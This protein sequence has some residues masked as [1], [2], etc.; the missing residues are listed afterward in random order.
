MNSVQRRQQ[1]WLRRMSRRQMLKGMV[2]AGALASA[3]ALACREEQ[4]QV[5]PAPVQEET[6]RPGGTVRA[7]LVGLSS[8]NPPTL[9]PYKELTYLAQIPASWHYS[10]LVKFQAGPNIDPLDF[11]VVEG[12]L[13][14]RWEIPDPQMY[15]FRLRPN[16]RFHNVPPLNGRPLT[17]EDIL[18]S[19]RRISQDSPNRGSWNDV[20]DRVEAPDDR[21][22]IVRLKKVFAPGLNHFANPELFRVQ[23]KELIDAGL[24][25]RP[26]GT[27]PFIFEAFERDVAIKWRKNPDYFIADRPYVDRWEASLVG[28]PSTI[29][30]NLKTGTFDLALLDPAVY[31]TAKTEVPDLTFTYNKNQ[32]I[33]GFYF[34]FDKEPW[35]DPR[36]RQALS[37]SI[38]RDGILRVMDPTGQGGWFSAI[39]QLV[40][41]WLDPKDQSRFGPNARYFQRDVAEARRLLAA[42]GYPNGIDARVVYS[43][44]YGKAY[45]QLFTLATTTARDAGF[46]LQLQP[47]EYA[48]YLTTTFRGN[49]QPDG[50]AIGPLYVAVEPDA[51]FFTVYHPQSARKN[52]GGTGPASLDKDTQLLQM[53]DA[54]R[55]ELNADR[56]VQ[57]IHD[58]QRYM[59]EKMYMVPYSALPG[60][61]GFRPWV[62]GLYYKSSFGYGA[63]VAIHVWLAR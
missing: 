19:A 28:D 31:N 21:T 18:F 3:S 14:E 6:P 22:V 54:Q 32:V 43:P 1:L 50:I 52:W 58:I 27:G 59:A 20:V 4:P 40:P 47:Q 23:P 34:N 29:I 49:I 12:D 51:I 46:R 36:V 56:R 55:Q 57:L 13:A 11:S 24:Q 2:A 16:I 45:E 41:F 60:V 42:A 53:F 25:E 44:V 10:R 9:D 17:A 5:T 26:V 61:G 33:G 48:A 7:P 39:S 15:I 38:D 35:N 30:A 8:G 37:M 63:E 62:R